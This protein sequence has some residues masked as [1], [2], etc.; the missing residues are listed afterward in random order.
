MKQNSSIHIFCHRKKTIAT[1][2][3]L[4][5]C[6]M[7]SIPLN[8]M[9]EISQTKKEPQQPPSIKLS[10]LWAAGIPHKSWL[11]RKLSNDRDRVSSFPPRKTLDSRAQNKLKFPTYSVQDILS[12]T[13]QTKRQI[14]PRVHVSISEPQL[15]IEG[16]PRDRALGRHVDMCRVVCL[17]YSGSRAR[18]GQGRNSLHPAWSSGEGRLDPVSWSCYDLG[19]NELE[20]HVC[21]SPR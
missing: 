19:A 18:V 15:V 14:V 13:A 17:V 21:W 16:W 3:F 11:C 8:I 2:I 7:G 20:N 10:I 5:T 4:T 1:T 6:T 12:T 9:W